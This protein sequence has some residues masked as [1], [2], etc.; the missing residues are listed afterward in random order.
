[1]DVGERGLSGRS[2]TVLA[3]FAESDFQRDTPRPA[4]HLLQLT[5]DPHERKKVPAASLGSYL[6][7]ALSTEPPREEDEQRRCLVL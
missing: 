2:Q 7:R 4:P 3:R 5:H 6:L 1:M